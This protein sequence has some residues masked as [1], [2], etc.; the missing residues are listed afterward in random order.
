MSL[1][2]VNFQ[3]LYERHLCRHS[4]YGINAIHLA[5]VVLSYFAIFGILAK[6]VHPEWWLFVVPVPYFLVVAV[7]LPY[8][9]RG[10][11]IAFAAICLA[12]F[13]AIYVAMPW[14]PIWLYPILIVVAHQV[15]SWSHKIYRIERDM[16]R[17]KE[18]YKKGPALFILLSLYELPILL[19]YLVFDWKS[20][21]A[22]EPSTE[23]SSSGEIVNVT[24]GAE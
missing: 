18:K 1:F 2:R 8:R 7:N 21:P 23:P 3:E 14:L 9:V 15:Q 10:V 13:I 12:A 16:T 17:F 19:N 5:T 11:S 4:E 22:S 20:W 6:F 24:V